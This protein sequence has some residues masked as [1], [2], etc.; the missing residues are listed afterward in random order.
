MSSYAPEAAS[1]T[2]D[3]T[4]RTDPG[5]YPRQSGC[6]VSAVAGLSHGIWNCPHPCCF[7]GHKPLNMRSLFMVAAG[8]EEI[9]SESEHELEES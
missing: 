7:N 2:P 1:M 3:S 9:F 4:Y 5:V 6:G 8:T